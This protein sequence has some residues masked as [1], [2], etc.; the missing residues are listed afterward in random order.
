MVLEARA[1]IVEAERGLRE[2]DVLNRRGVAGA[3]ELEEITELEPALLTANARLSERKR[4]LAATRARVAGLVEQYNDFTTTVS[5]MFVALHE[6]V[7]ALEEAAAR[8]ERRRRN[9][10]AA[11]Y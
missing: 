11:R 4:E 10:L 5:D 1:D 6:Q 8:A 2:I 7:S 9:E 3:G